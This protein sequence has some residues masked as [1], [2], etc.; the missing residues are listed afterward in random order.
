MFLIFAIIHFVTV[1][2]KLK[3]IAKVDCPRC[4]AIAQL[5]PENKQFDIF[6]VYLV[7]SKCRYR[8][9]I[10]LSTWDVYRNTI[11]IDKLKFWLEKVDDELTKSSLRAKIQK[12]E[13]VNNKKELGL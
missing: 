3:V 12:L 13:E 2:I 11:L 6:A 7:C 5:R 1:P 8:K 9:Y 4:N 10:G